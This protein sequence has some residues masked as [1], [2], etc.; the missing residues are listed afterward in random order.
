ML[1]RKDNKIVFHSQILKHFAILRYV[2]KVEESVNDVK[3]EISSYVINN[4]INT[5]MDE[6][7]I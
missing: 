1:D 7:K 3:N 2:V 5:I 4:N 6:I